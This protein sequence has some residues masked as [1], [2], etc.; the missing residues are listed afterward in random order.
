MRGPTIARK[1]DANP[2][3]AFFV[4]MITRDISLQDC[5][6]DLIDNS[7]DGAWK[8]AGG[9][10][11]GLSYGTELSKFRISIDV[12]SDQFTIRDNCGGITLEDA[13]HYAFT[14]GRKEKDEPDSFSIGVY[15]IGMKRA[16]FKMG[17]EVAIRSSY[18]KQDGR[19]ESFNVPINVPKW[20]QEDKRDWDFDIEGATDL[21]QDGVSI[22]V[23]NLNEE[24]ATSF[25]SP[26][27]LQELRRAISRDYTLHLRH[28][29]TVEMNGESMRGWNIELLQGGGVEPMRIQYVD[30]DQGNAVHVEILA[31]MSAPPPESSEP[32]DTSEPENRFGWYVVCN[33][34]IV[35]A[36][37]KT[38]VAGWGTDGW[39]S[40]HPQYS[41][42]LGLIF[43]FSAN[44]GLLPLTTTKRS[45]DVSSAVY[46]RARPNMRDASKQ[47][48]SY[49][50]ARKQDLEGA[51]RIEQQAKPTSIFD[52]AQRQT[53]ALPIIAARTRTRMA[54]IGYSLPLK[55]VQNLADA[56]GNVNMSYRDVGLK[57]FDHAYNDLVGKD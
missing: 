46:R 15:G 36:A 23:K 3:K 2:T 52:V 47:W 30:Q 34:R 57:S 42:F 5:I 14:F 22:S 12:K 19:R 41:G 53:V 18:T 26:S 4:R 1:A 44:A 45:V 35:L 32:S 8:K 7:I 49:T 31:G 29:L 48:I 43:F 56:L 21:D 6:L 25:G 33:G 20:L 16:V 50:N 54:N 55:K 28:G 24:T 40:W 9:Q 38:E 27:F 17:A 10:P 37:D 11:T 13:A 39:P 51:K